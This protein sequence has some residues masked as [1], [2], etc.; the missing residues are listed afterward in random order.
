MRIVIKVENLGKKYIISHQQEIYT[1]L[2]DV[3]TDGVK[4]AAKKIINPKSV[5]L[6]KHEE[7]W[8]LRNVYFE[9][10]KGERIGIIGRNR[11]G[12]STLLT[13]LIAI[14]KTWSS[15]QSCQYGNPK[16]VPKKPIKKEMIKINAKKLLMFF[17]LN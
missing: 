13:M 7:F 16:F 3:I 10:N 8:A 11:A 9:V 5:S 17:Y 4:R 1:S 15:S 6:P 12:K 2:R 14:D